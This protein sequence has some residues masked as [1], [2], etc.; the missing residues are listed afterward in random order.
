MFNKYVKYF[1]E[2]CFLK[3]YIYNYGRFYMTNM[4]MI[5]IILSLVW[6]FVVWLSNFWSA[7][8][9]G[10]WVLPE[11]ILTT[12]VEWF[13]DV[14][15]SYTMY[16]GI[17]NGLRTDYDVRDGGRD[18]VTLD[19]IIWNDANKGG[20]SELEDHENATEATLKVIKNLINWALGIVSLVALI[21]LILAGF[22]M[23]TA[24][25]DDAKFKAWSKALKKVSIWLAGIAVSWLMISLIF[26]VVEWS[27]WW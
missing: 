17:K 2:I 3:V 4:L 9:Q 27:M 5:K 13:L 22:Q 8:M 25:W 11:K 21:V 20:T 16:K 12:S 15:E 18:S 14:D 1:T 10:I 23:V 26:W 24:A 19:N 6:V 7:D